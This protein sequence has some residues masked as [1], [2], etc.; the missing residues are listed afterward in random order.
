M[1]ALIELE[2]ITSSIYFYKV[3]TVICI[4]YFI[5]ISGVP[6]FA[7][8]DR[9]EFIN[10]KELEFLLGLWIKNGNQNVDFTY[11]QA[12]ELAERTTTLMAEVHQHYGS[13]TSIQIGSGQRDEF[14]SNGLK[15]AFFYS[16]AGAYQEQF[17]KFIAEKYSLD[18]EWLLHNY[19]LSPEDFL[20]FISNIEHLI[21]KRVN[22]V[23][24]RTKT[25]NM[26]NILVFSRAELLV[27]NPTFGPIL[28]LL[29][30][31]IGIGENKEFDDIGKLN[32]FTSNPIIQVSKNVYF[33]SN[34]YTVVQALYEQPFYW[35]MRDKVY[36]SEA[37]QN[38]G[39]LAQAI[40]VSILK[41]SFD[42]DSIHQN[43]VIRPNK[44]KAITDIDVLLLFGSIGIVFQVKAK[45]L[46]LLSKQGDI[47]SIQKDFNGAVKSA[48]LQG[49]KSCEA[50]LDKGFIFENIEKYLI[51]KISECF[52]VT[53]VMDIYPAMALQVHESIEIINDIGLVS[54][55]LFDIDSIVDFI[56]KPNPIVRYLLLRAKY[57]QLYIA[58]NE[59]CFLGFHTAE[60]IKPRGKATKIMIDNDYAKLVDSYFLERT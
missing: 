53:V 47:Q 32:H 57:A 51:N 3:A 41:R 18:R 52:V 38:R 11:P 17:S 4:R 5:F 49:V 2:A 16:G 10:D 48:Y 23:E 42:P 15:E 50:L 21:L 24:I 36:H 44:T 13:L 8:Q 40:L 25:D 28:D 20:D 30:S 46:T 14:L 55:T 22:S 37:N 60:G 1:Q 9:D 43:I 39:K 59:M 54:L 7:H 31:T 34:A 6:N 12:L 27:G 26:L 29:V 35:M 33:I 56:Q 45:R 19:S 58:E